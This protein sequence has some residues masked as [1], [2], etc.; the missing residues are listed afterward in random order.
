MQSV[1]YKTNDWGSGFHRRADADQPGSDAID[2][3]TPTYSAHG[4][5]EAHQ[6][7]ER[8]LVSVRAERHREERVVQ[9]ADRRRG[10]RLHRRQFTHSGSN[11]APTDFSRSN[12]T[13]CVGAHQPPITV[14]T[15]PGGGRGVL[16]GRGGPAGR[17]VG[18]GPTAPMISK[19]EFPTTTPP[20]GTD[21]ISPYTYWPSGL[22]V[23]KVIPCGEVTYCLRWHSSA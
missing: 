4:R 9:R 20:S 1:D 23:G 17:H 22:T 2:G 19:V 7:L 16:A 5:P 15:S 13:S 10:R 18:R 21:T 14:P 11:A 8:H 6:R 3:W 12:G